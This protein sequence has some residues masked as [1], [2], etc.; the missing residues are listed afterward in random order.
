MDVVEVRVVISPIQ[1]GGLQRNSVFKSLGNVELYV[2]VTEPIRHV[3][4]CADVL[5]VATQLVKGQNLVTKK[6]RFES[7]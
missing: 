2:L 6:A 1:E 7:V 3:Q 5:I 4:S